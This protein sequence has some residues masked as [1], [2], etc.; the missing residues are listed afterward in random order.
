MQ[1]TV[2]AILVAAASSAAAAQKP[3]DPDK[4]EVKATKVAGSVWV[5]T[6]AGGNIGVS[7]GTDGD[8]VLFFQGSKVVHMGDD[9]FAGRFPFIDLGSGGNVQGVIA[10]AEKVLELAADDAKIIPGHGPVSTKDD[11]RAYLAMLK[12]ATAAVQAAIAAGKSLEDM[13][14]ENLLGKWADPWGTGF[15]KPDFFLEI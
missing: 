6:G 11:L 8:V 2:L 14:K 7:V 10:A 15:I 13:K 12:E 4:V 1:K 3:P 9:F 5:I